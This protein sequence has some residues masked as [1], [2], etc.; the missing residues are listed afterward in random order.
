MIGVHCIN[1]L[2]NL[3]NANIKD[4][5]QSLCAYFSHNLKKILEFYKLIHIVEIGV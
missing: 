2:T 3:T 4:V 5:F 1:H